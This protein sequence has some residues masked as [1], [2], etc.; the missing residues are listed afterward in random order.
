MLKYATKQY[1]SLT[2]FVIYL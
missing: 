1:K 2:E